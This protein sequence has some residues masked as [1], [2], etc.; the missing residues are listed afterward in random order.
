[1]SARSVG[2]HRSFPTAAPAARRRRERAITLTTDIRRA[3]VVRGGWDGHQPVTISDAFVPFLQEQGF[4]VETSEDLAVY[5]DAERLTATDLIVQC[6]TMGTINREQS[7]LPP[8]C[9]RAPAW[10]AGT[11][12]SSTA[13]TITTTT[14]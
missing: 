12:V 8:R 3:L 1:V 10:P 14:C 11:A 13:S 4:V 6:W 7:V 5:E 9:A 2:L